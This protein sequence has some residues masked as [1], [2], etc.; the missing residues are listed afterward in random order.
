MSSR[1]NVSSRRSAGLDKSINKPTQ[2]VLQN[3][4]FLRRFSPQNASKIHQEFS[5][6]YKSELKV[7]SSACYANNEIN[8]IR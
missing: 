5:E 3:Y 8:G 7:I 4:N 1:T 6:C 2:T